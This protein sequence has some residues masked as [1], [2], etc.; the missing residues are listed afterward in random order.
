MDLDSA[1]RQQLDLY[2]TLDIQIK[3]PDDLS[4]VTSLQ[5]RRKFR[6]K[7]LR[8]HPDKN[9]DSPDAA[10]KFQLLDETVKLL[11]NATT[12]KVYDSWYYENFLKR[13]EININT[14]LQRKRLQSRERA[15]VSQPYQSINLSEYEKYGNTLRKMK[16]FKIPYGD[17]RHIEK[18][19]STLKH[20]LQDSCT[21][22]LELSN[23]KLLQS[24]DQLRDLVSNQFQAAIFDLYYSSRNDY[25]NDSTIVSYVIFE[26]IEDTL[27][28]LE[29]W[30]T[31]HNSL[32]LQSALGKYLEDISPKVDPSI[33]TFDREVE[34]LP[35]IQQRLANDTI[36]L[37]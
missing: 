30:N 18:N 27:R 28:I 6:Q 36:Q 22:R 24:K 13:R 20:K 17:W 29:N 5:I 8:Y 7:A 23:N 2:Q 1:I 16:H 12:R 34:L 3:A 37:D 4:K 21:L 35:E 15:A 14:E 31:R 19:P 25:E 33:F 32:L 10:S 11:E 9:P 26:T